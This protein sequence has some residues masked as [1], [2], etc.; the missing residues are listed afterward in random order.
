MPLSLI[1]SIFVFFLIAVRQW[2]PDW[3]K[4]WMIM[5]FGA[6]FLLITGTIAPSEALKAID[7]NVIAYLF[8]VFAISHALFAS[9]ISEKVSN[10][11][12]ADTRSV[13]QILLFFI[14]FVTAVSAV[15]TNDAAAAIGTP[16]AIAIAASLNIAA[17]LPL[18]ALCVSV[19]VGSMFSPV[20]NPQNLLIVADGHFNNAVGTFLEWLAVPAVLSLGFTLLWFWYCF[21]KAPKG[22]APSNV[23]PDEQN[24][25][26]WPALLA[27]GLLCALVITDSLAHETDW[28][29]DLPLGALSLV[30]SIPLF[31]FSSHRFQLIKEVDWHTLIFFVSMFI[32][33]GAVLKSGAL[34]EWL[35]PW[36]DQLGEP[37]MVTSISFFGS[38][39]FSNVPLVEIYLNILEGHET[40]TLM[41]LSGISTLAGNLF[42]LSAASNVIIVQQAEKHGVAPF[43]FWQFTVYVLP[44]TIFSL[45]VCYAW[46]AFV[47]NAAG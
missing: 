44:V 19:T 21:G 35:S 33:T 27:T 26:Q 17:A 23:T 40:A 18:I 28:L 2:L 13:P 4:I 20:G 24:M 29:P 6:I 31:V 8:G 37:L 32:V 43:Q 16:I 41:L 10:W 47:R 5:T 46:V 1:V 25:R 38:Q 3:L 12:C 39:V 9:G 36:H 11:I 42:I 45:I 15:L 7:W 34:Q 22:D 30:A 14:L